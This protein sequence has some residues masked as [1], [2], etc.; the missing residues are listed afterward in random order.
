MVQSLAKIE[1]GAV[2]GADQRWTSRCFV[3]EEIDKH[4]VLVLCFNDTHH[5]FL[6]SFSYLSPLSP[7]FWRDWKEGLQIWGE[8]SSGGGDSSKYGF[9]NKAR[10]GR[11][12]MVRQMW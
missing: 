5:F 2:I 10:K 11:V 6:I 7:F 8:R 4:E 9:G 12:L 1:G 3:E